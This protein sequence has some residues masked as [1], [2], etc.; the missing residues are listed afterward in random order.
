MIK[1]SQFN[2]DKTTLAN[3]NLYSDFLN[4]CHF[5][6]YSNIILIQNLDLNLES[7]I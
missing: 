1:F 6:L 4:C 5:L 7:R 2:R 3:N